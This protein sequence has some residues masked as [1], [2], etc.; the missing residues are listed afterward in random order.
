MTRFRSS[1]T[2][3]MSRSSTWI[4]VLQSSLLMS[5]AGKR[6]YTS[7]GNADG[8]DASS[9]DDDASPSYDVSWGSGCCWRS[10]DC[11]RL[12]KCSS[13]RSDAQCHAWG[14]GNDALRNGASTGH[15]ASETGHGASAWHDAPETRHDAS[16]RWCTSGDAP[17]QLLRLLHTNSLFVLLVVLFV[18]KSKISRYFR[19]ESYYFSISYS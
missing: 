3:L 11:R 18:C 15:G 5:R 6:Y 10:W 1:S 14:S 2:W 16:T 9:R 7:S 12:S 17:E 4:T 8:D 19:L 13:W